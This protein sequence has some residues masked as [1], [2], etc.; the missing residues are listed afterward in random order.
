[1]TARTLAVIVL[2]LVGGYYLSIKY[3]NHATALQSA[4][5]L[6]ISTMWVLA[7]AV[8]VVTGFYF[9]GAIFLMVF[10]Y[11]W[12]SNFREVRDSDLRQKTSSW[13]PFGYEQQ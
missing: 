12:F 2:A 1:M 6:L 11:F 5:Q 10:A 9:A 3:A 8:T 4:V 13:N 7:A